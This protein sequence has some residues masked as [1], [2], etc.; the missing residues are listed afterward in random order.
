MSLTK[1]QSDEND[2]NRV[3]LSFSNVT[4]FW[5]DD[6]RENFALSSSNTDSGTDIEDKESA[7]TSVVAMD[8]LSFD[9]RMDELLCIIG[10]VGCGKSALLLAIAGELSASSGTIHRNYASLAYACQDPWIMDGTVRENITMG[11][12]FDQT[13][14]NKIVKACGLDVDFTQ[15]SD[16]DMT[17][18]G[19][20]C[21]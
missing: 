10:P 12:T 17:I 16:A 3:A 18:V 13:W 1:S 5:N 7:P 9:Y 20:F 6:W 15:F 21:F 14:Y 19:K 11:R 8:S 4:C 2:P